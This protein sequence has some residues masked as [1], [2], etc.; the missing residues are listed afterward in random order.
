VTGELSL[1]GVQTPQ[2]LDVGENTVTATPAPP[3]ATAGGYRHEAFLYS[4]LPEFLAG[5]L[6][7]I[8]RAVSA[9][10]PVLVV[11]SAAKTDLLRR[12]LGAEAAHVAF[13]DMADVGGNPARIIALWQSFV[14][15]NAGA[16]QLCGIGEPADPGRSPVELAEC[17]L[18]EALLNVAFDAATPLWLLCP[19]DLE[20]LGADVID[21][22][23]RTHPFVARGDQRQAS[24]VFE[25]IDPVE[26]FDR[27]LPPPPAEAASMSFGSGDLR[28]LRAFVAD[29]AEQA[30]LGA[31]SATGVVHALSE[32]ASNSIRHGGGRGELRIW[33][34]GN[35][36]V[37]EVSDRGHI[38]S[39]LVGRVR[40]M[41]DAGGAAGLWLA[42]QLC[43]LVQISS[44]ARGTTV[45]VRQAAGR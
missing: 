45:R 2:S 28:R 13:A 29:H 34:E 37:G 26:P 22:A 8:R 27:P 21:G 44:S 38:T 18:H 36:L 24:S 11:V 19:Y 1:W 10:D 9:G 6:S 20:A 30:G 41:R 31:D 33:T 15:G 32:I 39:P 14:Q 42:N 16:A 25:P 12:Q 3:A 4:G 35:I 43:D 17:Q 7:F 5:A 40:P 23:Q